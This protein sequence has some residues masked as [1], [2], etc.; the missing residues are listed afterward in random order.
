MADAHDPS[1]PVVSKPDIFDGT[2]SKYKAWKVQM[3][4]YLAGNRRSLKDDEDK[5]ITVLSFMK[6][7]LAGEF[8]EAQMENLGSQTITELW[9]KMDTHFHLDSQ[10]EAYDNLRSL[11]Q[12]GTAREYFSRFEL[13]AK[14]AGITRFEDRKQ[15]LI[16]LLEE[17]VHN[18]IIKTIYNSSEKLPDTYA[19][20][21][22]HIERIDDNYQQFKKRNARHSTPARPAAPNTAP[23]AA[24][25]TAAPAAPAQAP[26]QDQRDGTGVTYGGRGQP[27]DIDAARRLGLCFK[28]GTKGHLSRNC[29]TRQ[30]QQVR[31]VETEEPQPPPPTA[32]A[33]PTTLTDEA[34]E[35][36][37]AEIR[38]AMAGFVNGQPDA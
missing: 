20:Y 28:C 6:G 9:E 37:V 12:T 5:V 38:K 3:K 30:Q 27:M 36:L 34:R 21:K 35:F 13:Y 33:A 16:Q 4:L 11:K 23:R 10:N 1:R 14:Q 32:P 26:R 25:N 8:V 17:N 7:G 15:E 18:S 22:E 19:K 31:V 29:P 24:T 2:K